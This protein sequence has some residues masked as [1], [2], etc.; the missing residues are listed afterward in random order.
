MSSAADRLESSQGR[1][2][3]ETYDMVIIGAGFSGLDMLR[4]AREQGL[5]VIVLEAGSDLGGTWYW[6]RYPGA[7]TDSEAWYYC[8]S[9]DDE[10]LKKWDWSERYPGH[11]EM[12][13]Y[14]DVIAERY[15]VRRDVRFN[16]KMDS[17]RY[18]EPTNIWHVATSDNQ[19]YSC[20]YLVT[21]VG[22]M[23]E[24]FLPNIPGIETFGGERY[25]T[26]RWPK[27]EPDFRGKRVGII[28]AG[29]SAVQAIPLIAKRAETLTVFQRTANYVL[30]AQNRLLTSAER[31]NIKRDYE[32]VWDHARGHS[33]GMPFNPASRLAVE[34]SEEERD[35][36]FEDYWQRGGF[37]F[38]FETFDDLLTD[39]LANEMAADFI[40]KK[41]RE[42]VKNPETAEALCPKG[43][44]FGGKRPPNGT[45]YYETYN[46]KNVDLVDLKVTP[47]KEITETGVRTS[48]QHHEFDVIVFATGFDAVTGAFTSIDIQGRGGKTLKEHWKAG[49]RTLYGMG[50]HGFPNLFMVFGPQTPFANN[51][52]VIEQSATTISSMIEF[53]RRNSIESAEVTE[54]GEEFWCDEVEARANETVVPLGANANS[55]IYGA[56]IP[57]KARAVSFY[58][59]G[60]DMYSDFCSKEASE[61]FPNIRMVRSN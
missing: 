22:V 32:K 58:F 37:R 25:M 17:A 39:P 3:S 5:S 56:N 44:P 52:L 50:A 35:K 34:T 46:A 47:I 23:S 11:S 60:L 19:Y 48:E 13:N 59:G 55:W 1:E 8:Y 2:L 57:G 30:P 38:I 51:P 27:E 36:I 10:L 4:R 21:A 29:A 14:F 6:N 41:I 12:R 9:G 15:D 49:P 40:R 26:A 20:R 54:E 45:D 33:F 31:D 18:D 42:T 7:R 16:S 61:G 53:M 28:G 24:R 43:Y